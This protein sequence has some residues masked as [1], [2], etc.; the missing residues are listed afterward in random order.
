MVFAH[1]KVTEK[2][3]FQVVALWVSMLHQLFRVDCISGYKEDLFE[4]LSWY[5]RRYNHSSRK[6]DLGLRLEIVVMG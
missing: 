1:V 6:D 5:W 4:D 3:T 2:G